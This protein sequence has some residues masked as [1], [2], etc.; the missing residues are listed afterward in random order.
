MRLRN[1]DDY[2]N[3]LKSLSDAE[4]SVLVSRVALRAFP[5]VC[6]D[7]YRKGN[8]DSSK[9]LISRIRV[10]LYILE[11]SSEDDRGHLFDYAAPSIRSSAMLFSNDKR[12]PI[13]NILNYSLSAASSHDREFMT[14]Y[15]ARHANEALIHSIR[16]FLPSGASSLEKT[17]V[18]R[19]VL[20]ALTQDISHLSQS[21]VEGL[22]GLPLWGKGEG[23]DIIEK[24]WQDFKL[25]IQSEDGQ[26]NWLLTWIDWYEAYRDGRLPWGLPRNV[27]GGIVRDS[28]LWPQEEWNRGSEHI[29]SRFAGL[30]E[31][32]LGKKP[33]AEIEQSAQGPRFRVS[34]DVFALDH[35]PFSDD[36]EAAQD[37]RV[38][39]RHASVVEKAH[40][41]EVLRRVDNWLGWKGIGDAISHLVGHLDR[42][43]GEVVSEITL[44]Y[45]LTISLAS[46]Y[47][48]DT[49]VLNDRDGAI[50]PLPHDCRRALQDFIRT[51][52][53]WLRSFPS[54]VRDDDAAGAFLSR[55][56]LFAPI[57]I[58]L[59]AARDTKLLAPDAELLL[60][61]LVAAA[62][63]GDFQRVKAESRAYWGVRNVAVLAAS[64]LSFNIGMI[65]NEAAPKS[66]VAQK[67]ADFY[68]RA[69]GAI[70]EIIAREAVDLRL[71]IADLIR[72]LKEG[73]RDFPIV[74]SGNALSDRNFFRRDDDDDDDDN[75]GAG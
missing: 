27:A 59:N 46:F 3:V 10:L 4:I 39:K 52:A 14:G 40:G 13:G 30:I 47:E 53:P 42:S 60:N 18:R 63:R 2:K 19:A 36:L 49:A 45:D 12:I 26:G 66:I 22:L 38:R 44:I 74:P 32:R 11:A 33:P 56:E 50:E 5:L 9:L 61:E 35:K 70:S 23:P 64:L 68:L 15:Y 72:G 37:E 25:T 21:E 67:G 69:E 75:N 65:G 16:K 31:A 62:Q 34:E 28:L 71:A 73:R 51:A 7:A 6:S 24:V 48:Q 29:N 1:H 8:W 57:P 17:A 54:V 41:L 55:P 20:D 58:I 43:I